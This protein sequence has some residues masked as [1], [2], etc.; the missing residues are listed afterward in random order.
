TVLSMPAR[1]RP[2]LED[3]DDFYDSDLV[4]LRALDPQGVELGTVSDVVHSAA[5][6]L[7]VVNDAAGEHLVPFVNAIV[8]SVRLGEGELTIDAPSGLFEL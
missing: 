1:Q 8:P 5:G 2:E 7:L 6:D 3:P 4:G